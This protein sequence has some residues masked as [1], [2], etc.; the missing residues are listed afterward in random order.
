MAAAAGFAVL[1]ALVHVL[2]T[3]RGLVGPEHWWID[4]PG[5]YAPAVLLVGLLV[6]LR[7]S[8]A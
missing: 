2:D 4:V 3:V 5:V 1:H 8:A 6:A 7:R